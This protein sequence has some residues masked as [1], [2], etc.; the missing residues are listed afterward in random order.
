MHWRFVARAERP[1]KSGVLRLNH[2]HHYGDGGKCNEVSDFTGISARS[3]VYNALC[4]LN[5]Q[6]SGLPSDHRANRMPI[7]ILAIDMKD[8]CSR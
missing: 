3:R 6:I 2:S 4:G 5:G 7:T 8:M 1:I